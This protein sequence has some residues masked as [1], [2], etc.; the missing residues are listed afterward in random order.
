MDQF[1]E[2]NADASLD[3]DRLSISSAHLHNVIIQPTVETKN[4]VF[5]HSK[6]FDLAIVDVLVHYELKEP[7]RR[8]GFHPV[9]QS[10]RN[11]TNTQG[12]LT[13]MQ[14]HRRNN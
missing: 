13:Y 6:M 14:H 3:R 5:C 8:F 2:S 9:N 7:C 11:T 12:N 10:F 4:N 1:V